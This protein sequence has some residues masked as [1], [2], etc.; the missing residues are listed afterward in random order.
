MG[1]GGGKAVENR[2]FVVRMSLLVLSEA[3]PINSSC[4]IY[5]AGAR[6]R[7]ADVL[8]WA[9]GLNPRHRTTGDWEYEE[10]EK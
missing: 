8:M 5:T 1:E 10:Q 9:G 2:E 7:T 6:T 4:L 3:T